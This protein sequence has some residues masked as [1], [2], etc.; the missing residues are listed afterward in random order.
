MLYLRAAL[1]TGSLEMN[2]DTYKPAGVFYFEIAEPLI[3][4]TR[5]PEED[6]S[7]KVKSERKK[8]FK[9]DGVVIDDQGVIESIAG[10]FSGHSDI[11]PVKKTKDGYVGTTDR[12]ILTEEEFWEL[13]DSVNNKVK[14]LCFELSEGSVDIK[15][16]K[17]KD[18][19]ACRYCLYKSIC[20]FD[21]S[22]EG[23]SY[24]VVK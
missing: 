4:V 15:P 8:C 2:K 23:C 22:F 21:L 13:I 1:G 16:K 6:Y 12:K 7:E 24:D 18:E 20:C 17:V 14:E 19:T 11:L 10:E 5:M 9:L 3:D